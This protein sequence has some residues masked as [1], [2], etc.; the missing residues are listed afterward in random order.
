MNLDELEARARAAQ[1]ICWLGPEVESWPD[2]FTPLP[3]DAAFISACDPDTILDLIERA[4]AAEGLCELLKEV[5]SA[6]VS[7]GHPALS[8]VEVQVDV[9]TWAKCRVAV[10]QWESLART[11][12]D[13]P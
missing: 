2:P 5:S 8:Y 7:Y 10:A 1:T 9:D 6:G 12:E 4:R 11:P 3:Q 13:A